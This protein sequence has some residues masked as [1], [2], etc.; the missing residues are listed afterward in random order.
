VG[1]VLHWFDSF[2]CEHCGH[3]SEADGQGTM[4]EELRDLF[5][6]RTGLWGV[7]ITAGHALNVVK[8]VRELLGLTLADVAILKRQLPG[9]LF[10][11][12]RGE[13]ERLQN[14]LVTAGVQCKV[15]AVMLRDA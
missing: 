9:P 3:A 10:P 8:V 5:I 4:P 14:A 11:G 13:A 12:T 1:T 2:R 6:A 7:E 15:V